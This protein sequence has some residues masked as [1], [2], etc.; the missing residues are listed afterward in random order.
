MASRTIRKYVWLIETIKRYGGAATYEQLNESWTKSSLNEYGEELPKRTL[1]CQIQAIMEEFDIEIYCDRKDGYRYKIRNGV[2][3]ISASGNALVDYIILNNAL[4]NSPV[5]REK[6]K[7]SE[8]VNPT[9]LVTVIRAIELSRKIKVKYFYSTEPFKRLQ[10][11]YGLPVD[12]SKY[13]DINHE[14]IVEP[15][16]L[17][18]F[19]SWILI[20]YI[21]SL[22]RLG[23]FSL[24][25]LIDVK[26]LE[27]C[28]AAPDN[29]DIDKCCKEFKNTDHH[30]VL[31]FKDDSDG[32]IFDYINFLEEEEIYKKS[33]AIPEK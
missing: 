2:D 12:D 5:L 33:R 25:R 18:L 10:R 7:F 17:L 22:K 16:R 29:F 30:P 4:K 15:Y 31:Q 9:C 24:Y 19:R 21:P 23:F 14:Y 28:F 13:T 20:C 32:F 6:I 27:D 11:Q 8:I 26:I 1:L 3:S